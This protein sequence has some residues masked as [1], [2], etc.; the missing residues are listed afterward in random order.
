MIKQRYADPSPNYY[1]NILLDLANMRLYTAYI[2]KCYRPAHLY[3]AWKRNFQ[4]M[5]S[6]RR[7]ISLQTL[8]QPS[9]ASFVQC[10]FMYQNPYINRY[11]MKSKVSPD[12]HKQT[13]GLTGLFVNEHPHRSLSVV[14]GRILRALQQIPAN[15]AYRK[16]TEQVIKRRLALV[17]EE[18]NIQ[19]LEEKIGMGQLEEVVAQAENE[20][21]TVRAI[22]DSKA[23][24]PLV[25]EAP[26]GQWKWPVV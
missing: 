24:E 8:A 26:E 6:F 3:G 20:L 23:W 12:F 22:I 15:A 2:S 10:R 14:Y 21:R 25:E 17:E 11:K 13:T 4:P 18:P 19:A 1:V 9:V 16:Y 7:C 5:A